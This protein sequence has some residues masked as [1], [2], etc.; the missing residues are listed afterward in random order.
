MGGKMRVATHMLGNKRV[1]AFVDLKN[2]DT[3]ATVQEALDKGYVVGKKELVVSAVSGVIRSMAAN[4][5][6]DGNGRKIDGIVSIQPSVKCKLPDNCEPVTKDNVEAKLRARVL[7]EGAIDTSGWSFTV[8]GATEGLNVT[9]ITTG[10][11]LGEVVI[12]EAIDINGTGLNLGATDTITW[13]AE[14]QSGSIA[15]AKRTCSETRITTA[16]DVLAS[17]TG[18][19]WDGKAIVFTIVSGNRRAVKSATLRVN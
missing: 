8:E 9:T 14:T 19:E 7:K 10:E 2:L 15:A 17:L 11:V 13:T 1:G 16:A 3:D 4:I 18:G 6:K 5:S 12:G